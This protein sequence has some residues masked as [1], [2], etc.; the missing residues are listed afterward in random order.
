MN[1]REPNPRHDTL[2]PYIL[3]GIAKEDGLD[4]EFYN[5]A[6]TRIEDDDSILPLFTNAMV[7]ISTALAKKNFSGNYQAHVQVS[8]AGD[9]NESGRILT[10]EPRR[11]SSH[12]RNIPLS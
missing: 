2:V 12:T 11:L 8:F 1:S 10:W 9:P 7:E 5:E 4:F 6:M 3:D